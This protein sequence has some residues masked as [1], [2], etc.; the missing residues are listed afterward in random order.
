MD[1]I[2]LYQNNIW[3]WDIFNSMQSGTCSIMGLVVGNKTSTAFLA[4]ID[5]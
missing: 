4:F 2:V 5:L 3:D 1:E